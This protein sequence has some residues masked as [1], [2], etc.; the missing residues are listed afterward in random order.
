M[1]FDPDIQRR[2]IELGADLSTA[3]IEAAK[4]A[5]RERLRLNT[6]LTGCT[7]YVQRK[8]GI[9]YNQGARLLEYLEAGQFITAP[10]AVGE[11]HKGPHWQ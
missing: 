3:E 9:G 1:S 11:R 2:K 4:D 5:L 7:S 8:L 10:D 6:K